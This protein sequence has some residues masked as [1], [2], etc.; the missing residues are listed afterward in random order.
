MGKIAEHWRNM[1]LRHSFVCYVLL[2]AGLAL[3][4]CLVTHGICDWGQKQIL[5]KYSSGPAVRYYL[6]NEQGERLGDGAIIYTDPAQLTA[7]DERLMSW[8]RLAP[9]LAV[10]IYAALS[11]FAAA[12]LFWVQ[13]LRAPLAELQLAAEK[14][15][16]NDLD[17]ALDCGRQDELGQ[18]GPYHNN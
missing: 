7:A 5:A 4:L 11:I 1:P 9:S 14:I 12:W 13:K 8:L 6:T 2:F 15:A 17:F 10:P 16:E 18:T 3:L